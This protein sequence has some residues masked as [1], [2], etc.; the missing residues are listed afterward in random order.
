MRLVALLGFLG[1]PAVILAQ[2]APLINVTRGM[3]APSNAY[4]YGN[5]LYP[6]GIPNSVNSFA[7]RLGSTVAGGS[8]T[9]VA[10]G[11]GGYRGGGHS[12]GRQRTVVVPYAYPVFYDGGAGYYPPEQ[13]PTN[14]TVV[15]PQQ[16]APQVI[17]N[18]GYAPETA[19]PI[20]REYS[21]EAPSESNLRVYEGPK[22]RAEA[23]ARSIMDEQATIYLIA[24][25]DGSIRQAIGY[26]TQGDTFHY[27][28]PNSS[29]NH[30]SLAIV[31]RE[32]SV[33]LN[34]ERN[35]E[36]DIKAAH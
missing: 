6:G 32:R 28:T 29:V 34:A 14:V 5:I 35:L 13:Q 15:V 27:V 36:F 24:L 31:D 3:P 12:G 2:H 21:G 10:P 1:L 4:T 26:W 22:P 7:G 18:N 11:G 16:P 19:K 30:L 20:L 23:P 9:G 8:Y 17:I 25:K 33:E